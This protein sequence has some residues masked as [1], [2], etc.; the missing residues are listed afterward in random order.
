MI[1]IV[2]GL[3]GLGQ[4]WLDNRAKKAQAKN[5]QEV[6]LIKQAGSWE[7]IHARGSQHSWKD[8]FLLVVLTSPFI[9]LFYGALTNNQE[10][11]DRTKNAFIVIDETVP[12]EYWYLF[13]VAVAATFGVKKVIDYIGSRK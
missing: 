2:T 9:I 6:T 4:T 10:L 13:G 7:E 5:D 12:A 11:I 1:P 8:E 3:L